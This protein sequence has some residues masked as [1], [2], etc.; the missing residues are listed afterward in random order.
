MPERGNHFTKLLAIFF[1]CVM[2]NEIEQE[3]AQGAQ[4]KTNSDAAFLLAL[5]LVS[6]SGWIYLDEPSPPGQ[7]SLLPVLPVHGQA[8]RLQIAWRF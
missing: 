2:K 8:P 3:K 6:L 1:P 4:S 5:G 7:V